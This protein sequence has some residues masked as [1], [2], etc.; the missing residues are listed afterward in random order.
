MK[1][2]SYVPRHERPNKDETC[3]P[4][5]KKRN[6][7]VTDRFSLR[8]LPRLRGTLVRD[9]AG[10][11]DGHDD[12]NEGKDDKFTLGVCQSDSV[13]PKVRLQGYCYSLFCPH[14]SRC[15]AVLV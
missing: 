2:G 3:P 13:E 9:C 8:P 14:S 4:H 12:D 7:K 6:L 10:D 11:S 5:Q 15:L 1:L